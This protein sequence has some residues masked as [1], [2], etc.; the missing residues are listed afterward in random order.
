MTDQTMSALP[1]N[2]AADEAAMRDW[3]ECLVARGRTEGV[4][5]TGDGGLLIGLVH[6]VLQCGL[7]VEM[8]KHLGYER[9]APE[10]RG[11][12]F[13]QCGD[14]EDGHD[15]DRPGRSARPAGSGAPPSSR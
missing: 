5:L 12:E 2:G 7:E 13:A 15:R 11:P 10:S 4:S 8:A 3:A 14:A 9:H 6:Q 1:A